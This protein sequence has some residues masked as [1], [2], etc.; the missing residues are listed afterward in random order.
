[1]Y[2][3]YLTPLQQAGANLA[4]LDHMSKT[5]DKGTFGSERKESAADYVIKVEKVLPFSRKTAGFASLTLTKVRGGTEDEGEA[6]GYLW[7]PGAGEGS[8]PSIRQ[9]PDIPTLRNWAPEAVMTL[10]DAA[11]STEENQKEQAI[12]DAVRDSRLS[13]TRTDLI[14]H[15][16][17]VCPGMFKTPKAAGGFIDRMVTIK[18][19]LVKEEGVGGK[20][21]LPVRVEV[22]DKVTAER[23]E[24]IRLKLQ[25]EA[26][27]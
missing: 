12:I 15:V 4:L 26:G 3:D 24:E 22:Q 9:Y 6:A 21:D 8:G 1:V 18:H 5:G 17:D 10:A 7:M 16:I 25:G 14:K 20:Y 23:A 11:G 2:I 13:F 27:E 19:R